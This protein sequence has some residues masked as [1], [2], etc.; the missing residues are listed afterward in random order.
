MADY[1]EEPPPINDHDDYDA[2]KNEK[3]DDLFSSAINVR[4]H[5]FLIFVSTRNPCKV[6]VR[7]VNI[8]MH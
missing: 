7:T 3:E 6:D 4:A 5:F 8:T 1:R 2:D